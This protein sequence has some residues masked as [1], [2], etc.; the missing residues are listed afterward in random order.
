MT[1]YKTC[2][3]TMLSQN[4]ENMI[5]EISMLIP[6]YP[7]LPIIQ[8]HKFKTTGQ[9]LEHEHNILKK[10]LENKPKDT[11]NSELKKF[12]QCYKN[13]QH[14]AANLIQ[15]AMLKMH[16]Y[17]IDEYE[18][19]YS[20]ESNLEAAKQVEESYLYSYK[21]EDPYREWSTEEWEQEPYLDGSGK[22]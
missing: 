5:S 14:A 4:Y 17:N 13:I 15:N 18:S 6:N 12:E 2:V 3:V 7:T 19:D 8:L 21:W 9:Y 1:T 22:W 10:Q 11:N 20:T 16:Y